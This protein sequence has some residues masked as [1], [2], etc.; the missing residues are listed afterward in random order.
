MILL[1]NDNHPTQHE[2]NEYMI[3]RIKHDINR[4]KDT[5]HWKHLMTIIDKISI[6]EL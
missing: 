6:S 2:I 3:F 4:E 1:T 5:M